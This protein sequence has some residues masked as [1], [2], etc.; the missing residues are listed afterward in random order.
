MPQAMQGMIIGLL[1]SLLVGI[2][3]GFYLRQSR[4]TE[5]ATT[6]QTSQAREQT[7]QQEHEER[8]RT[9]TAQLQQDYEAQLAD[10]IER[11]QRQYEA[12]RQQ[13]EAE[14][15]ARQ[16][17][18]PGSPGVSGMDPQDPNLPAEAWATAPVSEYEARLRQQYEARLKEAAYKIQ[19]AYEQHLRDTLATERDAQQQ[20]YDQRLAEAIARYQDDA[21]ARL[22]AALKEQE[23]AAQA[24]GTG[25]VP[26]LVDETQVQERLATLEAEL[27]RTYDRRLAERIEQYQDE[28]S[29]RIAQLE[30]EFAA[31]LQMAQA[32]QPADEPPQP[33]EWPTNAD[34]EARLQGEYDQRLA[35]AVARHQDEL[36]ERTQAL[37][38]EYEA[39]LQLA[40][41]G[42]GGDTTDLEERL[43]QE[44]EPRLRAEYDL[45]LAEKLE[46]FQ[47][48]LNQRAQDFES[49]VIGTMDPFVDTAIGAESLE[50]DGLAADSFPD[51]DPFPDLDAF[52]SANALADDAGST[53]AAA[54]TASA[55]GWDNPDL[56]DLD[57]DGA[58]DEAIRRVAG[59][60]SPEREP[61]D[62]GLDSLDFDDSGFGDSGLEDS[63]L[64]DSG[65]DD[66]GLGDLN[67][68]D[69][70]LDD[71]S[72][73]AGLGD[74]GLEDAGLGDF[75]LDD[76]DLGESD[77][78]ESDLGAMETPLSDED[79]A[80]EL[81][82]A[83]NLDDLD[84]SAL[85]E[86]DL[87]PSDSGDDGMFDLETLAQRAGLDLGELNNLL[88]QP[89]ASAN[90]DA[91]GDSADLDDEDWGN[92]S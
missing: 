68:D 81:D 41:G 50:D 28:M 65:L 60:A 87:A 20:E 91:D 31:R 86:G 8:L 84:L 26:G 90:A 64:D 11:Y 69:S 12:Q 57:L 2:I 5:L 40:Q 48:G 15:E 61:E 52:Q 23:L 42:G 10:K 21:E 6:I 83:F 80:S 89:E 76:T 22:A 16:N 55:E 36:L 72:D 24:G 7:L 25:L 88:N 19:Q 46:Q 39:R 29:Q 73:D 34:L 74:F 62:A 3:I 67:W 77:L 70:D 4:I 56:G 9:A 44:L 17:L 71:A 54:G 30:Q 49:G 35:E 63:G 1:I 18:V 32:T 53:L 79:T 92:L 78:G 85:S 33:V 43:R 59:F 58:G 66:S 37:E 38:Q 82:S 27:R 75:G 51:A 13:L 45:Q 47:A 14:Y